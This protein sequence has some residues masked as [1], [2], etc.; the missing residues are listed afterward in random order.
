[1]LWGLLSMSCLLQCT[2]EGGGNVRLAGDDVLADTEQAHNTALTTAARLHAAAIRGGKVK[3]PFGA[4][5]QRPGASQRMGLRS[6]SA[7]T[8]H[9][10]SVFTKAQETDQLVR[11]SLNNA[12]EPNRA[13]GGNAASRG[14][15]EDA[16][17]TDRMTRRAS[18]QGRTTTTDFACFAHASVRLTRLLRINVQ[19]K[20]LMAKTRPCE[21]VFSQMVW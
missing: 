6:D 3:A 1:M 21:V 12:E 17:L 4:D 8:E 9:S 19:L 14:F 15:G 11:W 10:R 5:T 7:P 16:F 18:Q 2:T 13:S 20:A